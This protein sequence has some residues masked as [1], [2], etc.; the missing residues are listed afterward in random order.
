MADGDAEARIDRA[1]VAR[2]RVGDDPRAFEQLL[3]RHQGMVRA[4]LR[5]LLRGDIAA[6]DDLAQETF[7]LAWRKLDQFRGEARFSTWLYRI[8][9]ACFLQARRKR[10][11]AD[12][13]DGDEAAEHVPAA[14]PAVDLQMDVERAM[15]RL[16]AAEQ[17]VLLH[18]VQLGLSHDE[19]SYVLAMPLGTVK[20]HATRGKAKLNAMLAAWHPR[21][22]EEKTP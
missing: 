8:A 18:C 11:W 2:A 17:T 21:A 6:A 10:S 7:L 13:D 3:R 20:S 15:Q 4:Q 16:S 5:R 22:G 1:L 19:T 12:D 9:Y 14:M